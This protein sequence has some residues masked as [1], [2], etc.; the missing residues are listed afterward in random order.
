MSDQKSAW[1]LELDD[2]KTCIS[3]FHLI[4]KILILYLILKFGPIL[5]I[6]IKFDLEEIIGD[7]P[8]IWSNFWN[9]QSKQTLFRWVVQFFCIVKLAPKILGPNQG[10][11]QNL[12]TFLK[13]ATQKILFPFIVYF[14][15]SEVN[16]PN[17]WFE[18]RVLR[19]KVGPRQKLDGIFKINDPTNQCFDTLHSFSS[20]FNF[21]QSWSEI[22][23]FGLKT[24]LDQKF[25]AIFAIDES[26]NH[27]FDTMFDTVLFKIPKLLCFNSP[28]LRRGEKIFNPKRN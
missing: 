21:A 11:I 27:F 17:F 14:F 2:Q 25:D 24:E 18:I 12:T 8:K 3:I 20:Q 4:L 23:I 22:G 5:P 1:I 10:W 28:F 7:R 13:L 15:F 19:P 16:F 9:Q 26:T 6:W